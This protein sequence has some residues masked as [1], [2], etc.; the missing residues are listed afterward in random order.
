MGQHTLRTKIW[1]SSII[2]AF[3]VG[4]LTPAVWAETEVESRES[5]HQSVRLSGLTVLCPSCRQHDET[6]CEVPYQG[7][8]VLVRCEEALDYL[9]PELAYDGYDGK[10]PSA[11]ELRSFLIREDPAYP[12]AKAAIELLLQTKEGQHLLR[13]SALVL[14]DRYGE[15]IEECI[16]NSRGTPELWRSLWYVGGEGNSATVIRL[17][18]T[19]AVQHPELDIEDLYLDL[20]IKNTARDIRTLELLAAVLRSSGSTWVTEFQKVKEMLHYCSS[21]S[22][23]E[24]F[25]GCGESEISQLSRAAQSYLKRVQVQAVLS[26]IDQKTPLPKDRISL[27]A[28]IPYKKFR[29]PEC[30]SVLLGALQDLQ[31][32]GEEELREISGEEGVMEMLSVFAR[33]D[34]EI[35]AQVRRISLTLRSKSGLEDAEALNQALELAGVAADQQGE[36]VARKGS[37]FPAVVGTLL[38]LGLAATAFRFRRKGGECLSE[39]GL[40]SEER[41]ELRRLRQYFDLRPNASVDDLIKCYRQKARTLH[42]DMGNGNPAEFG[43]LTENYDR[44]RNL[45]ARRISA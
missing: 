4:Y 14:I 33:N 44:A 37:I 19:I 12:A 10:H 6:Y 21:V 25:E 13:E 39:A 20:S 1:L 32:S 11:A 34:D 22:L 18:A 29:T 5:T 30:H 27:L 3:C 15:I 24:V 43:M 45:L 38:V 28:R 35:A 17:R 31:R 40:T 23:S 36:K 8:D 16:K 26:F 9:L 41:A 42:P 7:E 2:V